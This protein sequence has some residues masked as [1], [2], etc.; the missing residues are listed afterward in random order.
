M[1]VGFAA[2]SQNLSI[3]ETSEVTNNWD[4]VITNVKTKSGTATNNT[5]PSY[6][7][8]TA[9]FDVNFQ[10]MGDYI[11]YEVT[12]KNNGN[13]DAYLNTIEVTN[14]N[15]ET[16]S[17]TYSGIETGDV[18]S[19]LESIT[20]I[21]KLSYLGGTG[22]GSTSI[23]IGYGGADESE[24]PVLPI[25]KTVIAYDY[26]TN[27]GLSGE[28][29][30]KYYNEGESVDLNV[31]GKKEG[32]TFVGWNTD[33]DAKTALLQ[34]L[35]PASDVTL[36]AIYKK[37]LKA[38][39]KIGKGIYSVEKEEDIC[40]LYNNESSC[41]LTLPSIEV[42]DGFEL[43]GWYDEEGNKKSVGNTITLTKNVIYTAKAID[44]IGPILTLVPNSKNGY[45]QSQDVVLTIRDIDSGLKANQKVYYGWS[46]SNEDEPA[47]WNYVTTTNEEGAKEAT[48][49]IPASNLTGTYYLWIMTGTVSDVNEN[50]NAELISGKFNFDND[51]PLLSAST[52]STSTSI[53]V[54]ANAFATSGIANYEYS[55]D[56][57]TTW[58][59]ASSNVYIFDDLYPNTTYTIDVKVTS[60]VGIAATTSIEDVTSEVTITFDEKIRGVVTINYPEVCNDEGYN[61]T[62]TKDSGEEVAVTGTSA[63]VVFNESGVVTAETTKNDNYV[64]SASYTYVAKET[65][66]IPAGSSPTEVAIDASGYYKIELWGAQGGGSVGGT[67][68]HTSG[69]I[70]LEE[71]DTLYFYVGEAGSANASVT[72]VGGYNGGGYSG[73]NT[74]QNSFG[75]GGS[76]DVRLVSGA[77]NNANSLRSRL[78]VAAG[79]GGVIGNYSSYSMLGGLGGDLIGGTPSGTF[80]SVIPTGGKQTST[81][82]GYGSAYLG[83]FGY[84]P[85]SNQS[86][87]GGGGGG[88][89]YGGVN[90]YGQGGSGGSSYI[91]GYAG[92]NSIT[93]ETSGTH[94]N[95]TNHYSGKYFINNSMEAGVKTGD[96]KAEITYLGSPTSPDSSKILNVRYIKDCT[97]GSSANVGNYWVEI[98]AINNG[99]NVAKGKTI[100]GTSAENNSTTHAYKNVVDGLMDNVTGTSGYGYSSEDG[101]QCL[102]VDLGQEYDLEEVA[103][104][105]YY[106]DGRTFYENTTSVAGENE[107]YRTIYEKVHEETSKGNHIKT[108]VLKPIISEKLN[109]DIVNVTIIYPTDCA[110]T[111]TC[112]YKV[113][114]EDEVVV[115]ESTALLDITEDSMVVANIYENESLVGTNSKLIELGSDLYVSSSG[116]DTTGTGSKTNPY[117]TLQKA[118]NAAKNDRTIYIMD[119]ITVDE[120]VEF[121]E[122]KKVTITSYSETN[123]INSII[124]GS[125]VTSKM[126]NITSGTL[127][128]NNIIFDGNNV[129]STNPLISI[130]NDNVEV[131]LDSGTTIKDCVNTKTSHSL[132]ENSAG[133]DVILGAELIING[134]TIKNNQTSSVQGGGGIFTAGS[135][136]IINDGEFTDNEAPRG[137]FIRAIGGEV[138]INDGIISNNSSTVLGGAIYINNRDSSLNYPISKAA[139]ITIN[140]GEITENSSGTGG[141]IYSKA[142]TFFLKGGLIEGNKASSSAGGISVDTAGTIDVSGGTVNNNTASSS[143]ASNNI[144]VNGT[145]IDARTDFHT[146]LTTY[147]VASSLNTSYVLDVASSGTTNGTNIQLYGSNATAAQK[148]DIIPTKVIDDIVYYSF[149]SQVSGSTQ[150]MWTNGNSAATDTNV[151]TWEMHSAI[152][153]YWSMSK[154]D[155]GSYEIKNLAGT[156]LDIDGGTIASK[157][158]IETNTCNQSASQKWSLVK[159]EDV[160]VP[161]SI[162]MSSWRSSAGTYQS[163]TGS[164]EDYTYN[165]NISISGGTVSSG[166]MCYASSSSSASS[167]CK[168]YA[169]SGSTGYGQACFNSATNWVY[170]RSGACAY[171]YAK[172]SHG[173]STSKFQC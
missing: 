137:G 145:L 31:T 87:W 5:E 59:E 15:S 128:T 116:N 171:A 172:G 34:L 95:G 104:W 47:S 91:S 39:Y 18:L 40:T 32:Y 71:G 111:H 155:D 133:V 118:Y 76:T 36:Y 122:D 119:D 66:P 108:D 55:I 115:T 53:T 52:S 134:A 70:Y 45:V 157:Q 114:D 160:A 50:V 152:G 169:S 20:F 41:T 109:E 8:L 89:Y 117:A 138:T 127:V 7:N 80:S 105:H 139:T 79:G 170:Y 33:K 166:K 92:V 38:T 167:Y 28:I 165:F 153:G 86:G 2:F 148:W 147:A 124:R 57:G 98:Q 63:E 72:N 112:T 10:S 142:E 27:G 140:G 17:M 9:N 99:V 16:V 58:Y 64:T 21:V 168:N 93:S 173:L 107:V 60:Y 100:T 136:L 97:N 81:G 30:E 102:T 135:S 13:V 162:S 26:Q 24:T 12:V 85:Q 23:K 22:E 161:N 73:N 65:Q 54:T 146:N 3:S 68:A 120:M 125:S 46:I 29:T 149:K 67:G 96:G 126:I 156:C 37:D 110:S 150:Y 82:T 90:G 151:L 143:I 49:T 131:T 163:C 11:E 164:W 158:N 78:M 35:A 61:C 74:A 101:N 130:R 42:K 113:N 94:T 14:E 84:A 88:G 51:E 44:K 144:L 75:G 123:E 1:G 106:A 62:Y 121:S 56:G 83:A 129:E 69:E 132:Y 43:D 6:E 103:V 154:H 25:G 77:W 48:V 19:S 159:S 4:I 141:A